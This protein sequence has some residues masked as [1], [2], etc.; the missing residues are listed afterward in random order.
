MHSITLQACSCHS[1]LP[2]AAGTFSIVVSLPKLC[3]LL[4]DAQQCYTFPVGGNNGLWCYTPRKAGKFRQQTVCTDEEDRAN[5]ES[6]KPMIATYLVAAW[7][8]CVLSQIPTAVPE[9]NGVSNHAELRDFCCSCPC[10]LQTNT[11]SITTTTILRESACR[12]SGTNCTQ[13]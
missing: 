12:R 2:A 4:G 13:Q 5:K 11:R 8:V 3:K 9:H 10:G 6:I 1:L 7:P